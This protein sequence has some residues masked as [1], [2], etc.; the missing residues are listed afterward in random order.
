MEYSKKYCI[1]AFLL[2]F[3]TAASAYNLFLDDKRYQK[4]TPYSNEKELK[5]NIGSAFGKLVIGKCD[6]ENVFSYDILR[7]PKLGDPTNQVKYSIIDRIGYLEIPISD[8][9]E[10]KKKSFH[11]GSIESEKWILDFTGRIP[12]SMDIQLGAGKGNFDFTGL[13]LKDLDISTGAS[14]VTI[15]FNK[16]N[17]QTI[18]N[19]NIETGVSKFKAYNLSNANFNK[20]KFSGGIGS[21]ELDFSGELNKEVDVDIEIGLGSI[22]ILIP[23]YVGAK[24]Y[25]E[26]NWVSNI[27]LDNDFDEEQNDE[28]VTS[29]YSSSRGKINIQIEAGLGS[30]KVKRLK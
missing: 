28:Y 7:D 8:R 24:V 2:F 27:D 20:L 26:K 13:K 4:E 22:T 23:K 10:S 17:Q 15:M 12:I 19:L 3:T 25:Y 16:L 18:E 21:Y 6:D 9:E 29:N 14:S 30:V 1:I 11:I 5:V